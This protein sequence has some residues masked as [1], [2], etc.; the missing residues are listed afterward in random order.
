MSSRVQRE[1]NARRLVELYEHVVHVTEAGNAEGIMRHGLLATARLLDAFEA[2]A[3]TRAAVCDRPRQQSV[4]LS[5][6]MYGRAC[7]RDQRP[8][9]IKRLEHALRDG[10]TINEWLEL[11]DTFVFFW[12]T[13]EKAAHLLGRATYANTDHDVLTASTR[14]LITRHG[15]RLRLSRMN[16]GTT[17]PFAF[18]RGQ[19]TF[20][21]LQDQRLAEPLSTGRRSRAVAEIAVID[22]VPDMSDLVIK[23]ERWHGAHPVEVLWE[24]P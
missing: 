15:D 16:T 17:K 18:P 23:I 11:L 1:T 3:A 19:D 20:M 8:M 13:R 14:E 12:P 4:L 2:D 24:R 6:E 7:V 10:M 22:G 21:E 5:H 9:N